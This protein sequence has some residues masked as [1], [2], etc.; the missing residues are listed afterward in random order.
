MR[1]HRTR[2]RTAQ[3]GEKKDA[4]EQGLREA[5]LAFAPSGRFDEVIRSGR[6][7]PRGR[8]PARVGWAILPA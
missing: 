2:F 6:S 5:S 8:N 1:R 3:L 7:S 4:S